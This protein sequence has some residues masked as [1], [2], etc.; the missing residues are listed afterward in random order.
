[1]SLKENNFENY[2]FGENQIFHEF[3]ETAV[4]TGSLLENPCASEVSHLPM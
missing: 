3:C 2:F 1:M 4:G